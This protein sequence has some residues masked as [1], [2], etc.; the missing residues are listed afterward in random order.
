MRAKDFLLIFLIAVLLVGCSKTS[1][2]PNGT[3]EPSGNPEAVYTGY[4][5]G[6]EGKSI[7]VVGLVE[8]DFSA[9]G[10]A[11]HYYEATWFSNAGSELEIG[12]R[13]KVWVNGPI[14]ESYP[15]QGRADRVEVVE[16]PGPGG[17]EL[18][19]AEAIRNALR[20]PDANGLF[21][22]AIKAVEFD[23][24]MG[25][26]W[27]ELTQNGEERTIDIAVPDKERR[28]LG[29]SPPMPKITVAGQSLIVLLST[30]CWNTDSG[31]YCKDYIGAEEMLK[32][33]PVERVKP[34][35]KIRFAFD[36]KPPTE[37]GVSRARNRSTVDVEMKGNS[38]AAPK[39]PGVYYYTLGANWLSDKEK[40]ISEGDAYFVFAVEVAKDDE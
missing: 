35:A 20:S 37:I 1:E 36:S 15:G 7:L 11:R 14:A 40:R 4:I 6:K 33:K 29:K 27:V 26:W 30:H 23:S 12:Q 28:E 24:D 25:Q 32:D 18:T 34:G 8:R 3:E 21:P 2:P 5:V 17:A 16:A 10:G 39:E 38:F 31:G 9:N 22:P 13:V 19:E